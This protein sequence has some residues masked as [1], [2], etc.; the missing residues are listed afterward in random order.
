MATRTKNPITTMTISTNNFI[1]FD[2]ATLDIYF[3]KKFNL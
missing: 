1:C 3:S 2:L